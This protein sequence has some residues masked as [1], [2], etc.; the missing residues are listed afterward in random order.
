MPDSFG[1][2]VP[3]VKPL[4][5]GLR[6]LAILAVMV[7]RVVA[8]LVECLAEL[9]GIAAYEVLVPALRGLQKAQEK[10]ERG[11]DTPKLAPDGLVRR[12]DGRA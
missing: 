3:V 5:L 2:V 9:A 6:V 12:E 11:T 7:V 4:A 1:K 10:L 8:A